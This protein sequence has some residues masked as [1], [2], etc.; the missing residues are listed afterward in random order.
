MTT[1]SNPRAFPS[2]LR[3]KKS[4]V[5]TLAAEDLK[6]EA[7]IHQACPE[8]GNEKMWFYTL[9]IRSADE[10]VGLPFFWVV[11]ERVGL[12]RGVCAGDCVLSV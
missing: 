7:E 4:A 10:G 2:S 11:G 8:C 1:N 6:T 5:Q 9:Q 12:M 3:L